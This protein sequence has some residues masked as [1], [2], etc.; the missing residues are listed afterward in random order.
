[1][2]DKTKMREEAIRQAAEC[3]ERAARYNAL[4]IEAERRGD[5]QMSSGIR[6]QGSRRG[7]RG[8]PDRGGHQQAGY[9]AARVRVRRTQVHMILNNLSGDVFLFDPA[10]RQARL[11]ST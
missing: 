8:T 5:T 11:V 3:R 10:E 6:Q 1:M 9:L 4:S 2:A 7:E